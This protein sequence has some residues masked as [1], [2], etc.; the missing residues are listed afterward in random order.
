MEKAGRVRG[1]GGE[2][3]TKK[4]RPRRP[5]RRDVARLY[6]PKKEGPGAGKAQFSCTTCGTPQTSRAAAAAAVMA[7][8]EED[9]GQTRSLGI[10]RCGMETLAPGFPMPAKQLLPP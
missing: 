5:Q 4:R 3:A 2:S 8:R 6:A 10:Q 9:E 1:R 7:R